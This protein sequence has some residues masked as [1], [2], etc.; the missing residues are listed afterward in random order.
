MSGA[1]CVSKALALASVGLAFHV[2]HASK[3]EA[4]RLVVAS[5]AKRDKGTSIDAIVLCPRRFHVKDVLFV[6]D[7]RLIPVVP[8]L[9]K[10]VRREPG[11]RECVDPGYASGRRKAF[12]RAC[13]PTNAI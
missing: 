7:E 5:F 1:T 2:F 4:C 13:E 11:H 3:S 12:R 6:G 9:R 10:R 8:C